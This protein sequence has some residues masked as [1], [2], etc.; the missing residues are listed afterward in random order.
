MLKQLKKH[1][2][3]KQALS[4]A[5]DEVLVKDEE[6]RNLIGNRPILE[7]LRHDKA[8]RALIVTKTKPVYD[9]LVGESTN[10]L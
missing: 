9:Q 4:N 6:V 7:A 3:F 8:V 1:V 5:I 2:Q 10:W